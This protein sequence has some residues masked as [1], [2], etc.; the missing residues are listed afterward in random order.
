MIFGLYVIILLGSILASPTRGWTA[1][2]MTARSCAGVRCATTVTWVRASFRL[3]DHGS[4]CFEMRHQRATW[5]LAFS[6]L[7]HPGGSRLEMRH[8]RATWV[9]AFLPNAAS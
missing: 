2:G 8:Q 4:S 1:V 7:S 9:L 6:R 3:L 5:V